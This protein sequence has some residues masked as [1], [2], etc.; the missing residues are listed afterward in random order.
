MQPEVYLP[1]PS[2]LR[3]YIHSSWK[4]PSRNCISCTHGRCIFARTLP[5]EGT[6]EFFENPC[7]PAPAGG[8]SMQQSGEEERNVAKQGP[9]NNERSKEVHEDLFMNFL[10]AQFIRKGERKV[11][12]C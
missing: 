3:Y 1:L 10:R 9:R 6:F 8:S 11:S 7:S 5:P 12:V 2:P 4:H